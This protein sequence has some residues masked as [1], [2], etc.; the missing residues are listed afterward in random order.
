MADAARACSEWLAQMAATSVSRLM[1]WMRLL[2]R[3][4]RGPLPLRL[5]CP[6]AGRRAWSG[7]SHDGQ[8]RSTGPHAC[9]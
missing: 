9:H 7:M 5:A 8:L 2:G 6:C 1:F 4:R 3:A